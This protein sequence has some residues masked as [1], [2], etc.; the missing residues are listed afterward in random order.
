M[1]AVLGAGHV[2][3]V[4]ARLAVAGG[5]RVSIAGSGDPA[6]IELIAQVLAPG[7]EARWAADAI[8]DA[9]LVVL[10]FPLHRFAGFA[11]RHGTALSGRLVVDAMNYWPP[12]DGVLDLPESGSSE[13]VQ[14]E[15]PGAV[16]VKT[17]N[18]LGYHQLDENGD[19]DRLALGVAGND[20]AA[21][22]AVSEVVGRMGFDPVALYPLGAGRLLEPGGP[23]F[24]AALRRADFTE[25][26]STK[27]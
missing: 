13:L 10:A 7:A 5:Y 8:E 21:V 12:V 15:L 26:V 23:V 6:R 11:Q 25:A 3:P 18:H 27:A 20:P 1:I 19:P 2:G 17:F 14:R 22:N 9:D 24:G 16:V 4:L